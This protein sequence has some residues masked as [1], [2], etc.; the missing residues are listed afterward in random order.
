ML[1]IDRARLFERGHPAGDHPEEH[2]P[3]AAE[4]QE[5]EGERAV[6]AGV[7]NLGPGN[8]EDDAQLGEA[9]HERGVR[10]HVTLRRDRYIFRPVLALEQQRVGRHRNVAD[11]ASLDVAKKLRKRDVSRGR[12]TAGADAV[13]HTCR[14][15]DDENRDADP[16]QAGA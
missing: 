12:G 9:G 14:G 11:A 6:A 2:E 5:A 16:H 8:V 13:G 4:E 10:R 15:N 1:G 3:G 7:R